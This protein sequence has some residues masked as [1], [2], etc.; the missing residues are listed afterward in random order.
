MN[1]FLLPTSIPKTAL[2]EHL[3]A[4]FSLQEDAPRTIQR[5]YRD[6]FDWQLYKKG[7]LF[8]VDNDTHSYELNLIPL[9]GGRRRILT[10]QSQPTYIEDIP[11][12]VWQQQLQGALGI[13]A[14][15][16]HITISVRQNRLR[17]VDKDGKTLARLYIEEARLRQP[18]GRLKTLETRIRIV[19]ITGY[20]K[21]SEEISKFLIKAY[22]L[23]AAKQV[24]FYPSAKAMGL[25][26][27]SYSNQL[28]HPFSAQ[29]RSDRALKALL[30]TL[31]ETMEMNEQGTVEDIDSEFLH[32][33]RVAVRRTR[34][35]LS[36]IQHIFPQRSLQ[37]FEGG[38]SWVGQITGPTRDMHVYLLKF[39]DYQSA[40]P[41]KMQAH[42]L[43]LKEFLIRHQKQE[44][45]KL[46]AAIKSSRYQGLKQSWRTFLTSPC[47]EK[48]S[49][50]NATKPIRETA[51]THIWQAYSKL[52]KR[53]SAITDS[54]PDEKLHKLRI[55]AKKLRYLLEFFQNLYP[56]SRIKPL[57]S[58][59]KKLQDVLGDFQD[60]SVQ[61]DALKGFEVQMKEE[62]TL[63]PD[64]EAA[65][66]LLVQQLQSRIK[67]Q[68][69]LFESRFAAFSDKT[70]RAE[71]KLLFK[72]APTKSQA[73]K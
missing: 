22:K 54:C 3:V 72:K 58:T 70:M 16:N 19:P 56:K 73:V 40:L 55:V 43:P 6:T 9:E 36:Q 10:M 18:N 8:Q 23:K 31:L 60:L 53:G 68:R 15:M 57:I 14:L 20:G 47:P 66:E 69:K 29:D 37:R 64:T 26:V 49:L 38:F 34:S 1:E 67:A 17:Y 7:F 5:D 12:K 52:I 71:F 44:Q 61:I 28:S 2:K 13:R 50:E 11:S 41:K 59:L 62:G 45:E 4:Q 39:D 25:S 65:I 42:L 63:N 32:D 48:T 51:D 21:F 46:V 33:L 27:N 24:S 35:A 30:L